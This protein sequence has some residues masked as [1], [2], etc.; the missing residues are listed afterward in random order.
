MLT[1]FLNYV[2][3]FS[4]CDAVKTAIPH[5]ISK[6]LWTK[7]KKLQRV[8]V[9]AEKKKPSSSELV[10]EMGYDSLGKQ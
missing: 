7:K 2:K 5:K 6:A 8:K 10:V 1:S 3:T 9:L 4:F